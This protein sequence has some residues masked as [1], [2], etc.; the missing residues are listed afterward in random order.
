MMT[1]NI[2]TVIVISLSAILLV[3]CQIVDFSD[4]FIDSNGKQIFCG[5]GPSRQE[6][7]VGSYCNIAP[8]DAYAY[9]ARPKKQLPADAIIDAGGNPIECGPEWNCGTL[10]AVCKSD[11]LLSFNYCA[12]R[13]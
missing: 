2:V 10:V 13:P 6:C 1:F 8:N 3:N 12:H 5:W 11:A 9:C 4:A 7:P